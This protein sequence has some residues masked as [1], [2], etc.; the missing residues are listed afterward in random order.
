MSHAY[1]A[2]GRF[3]SA[4]RELKAINDNSPPPLLELRDEI[5]AHFK[6]VDLLP[7]QALHWLLDRESE[8]L[9]QAA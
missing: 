6:L 1:A 5:A 3:D 4:R 2:L 9:L 7:K 8:V